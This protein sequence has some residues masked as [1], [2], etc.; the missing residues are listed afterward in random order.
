MS[1]YNV[2]SI[3]LFKSKQIIT[4]I[5]HFYTLIRPFF[6]ANRLEIFVLNVGEKAWLNYCD[7]P[8]AT[9]AAVPVTCLPA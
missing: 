3:L 1:Y 2:Y 7:S 9:A 8:R 6:K 5:I 4:R